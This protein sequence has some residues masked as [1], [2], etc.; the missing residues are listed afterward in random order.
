MDEKDKTLV[1]PER[2]VEL[3]N[4]KLRQHPKYRSGMR[5]RNL[6]T[7]YDVEF[8]G[9]DL[10]NFLEKQSLHTEIFDQVALQ[11]SIS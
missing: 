7:G 5:F 10:Q 6:G 4:E 1:S 2:F 8:P 9:V 3:L 11:Y